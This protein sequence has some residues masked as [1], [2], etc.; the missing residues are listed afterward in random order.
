ME[1]VETDTEEYKTELSEEILEDQEDLL[2][3]TDVKIMNSLPEVKNKVS[4]DLKEKFFH[5]KMI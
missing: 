3:S 4:L 5:F 2:K 1:V